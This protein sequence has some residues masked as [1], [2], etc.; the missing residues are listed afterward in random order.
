MNSRRLVP[1]LVAAMLISGA[2]TLLLGRK[3]SSKLAAAPQH[4]Y[5]AAAQPIAVGEIIKPQSLKLVDWPAN[6]PLQGGFEKIDAVA[7]RA[8]IYPVEGGQPIIDKDLAAPGAGL[9]ITTQIPDGMR[10]IALKSDD[11]VGVAGFVF[12]GSHVDVLVTY[13]APENPSPVTA[14]VLQDSEVLATG[15]QTHPDPEGKPTV[16]NVV[17][18]LLSPQDAEKVELASTQGTIHFI[19]RNGADQ[20]Q[21]NDPPAQLSQFAGTQPKEPSPIPYR[22]KYRAAIEKPQPYVVETILGDKT[23]RSS[24]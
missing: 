22:P 2:C 24:F 5:V 11:I 9:G 4:Q 19:L 18:L 7:G 20:K 8:A 1:A 13:R 23:E 14:T 16:V 21:V 12:P 17:T 6:V 3:M 15:H 10:A